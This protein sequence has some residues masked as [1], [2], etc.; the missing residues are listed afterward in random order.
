M[1]ESEE[2]ENGGVSVVDVDFSFD[3]FVAVIVGDAVAKTASH[4][5][6][7][8]PHREAFVIVVPAIAVG[9]VGGASELAPQM[10]RAMPLFFIRS[11][12]L[13]R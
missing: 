7:G 5:S 4:S 13:G 11:M 6:A 1:I 2:V 10:T 3:G 8:H 9:R 12:T